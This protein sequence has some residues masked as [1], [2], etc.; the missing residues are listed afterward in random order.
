MQTP[1][2]VIHNTITF[3][4]PDR[5][6]YTFPDPYGSDMFGQ[7]FYPSPDGRPGRGGGTDEW[8]A[9]WEN[10]GVSTLGEVKQYPLLSWNDFPNLKIPDIRAPGRFDPIRG[11]RER[12]GDQFLYGGGMSIYERVHFIRGFENTWADIYNEPENLC[13]LLDILVDMNL[14]VIEQFAAE[15]YDGIIFGDDWGLQDRLMI[16]PAKWREIWKPRYAKMFAAAHAGGMRTM[17]HS[18]GHIVEIMDDLIEAG[19]DVVHMD[20]QENM[21]LD[22]LSKRFA[23]RITF[24]SCADIQTILP[25]NN[26]GLI[27]AYCREMVRKLGTPRGGFIAR[28]YTDPEGVGHKREAI[29][30]MCEE[31]L[32]IGTFE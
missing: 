20:Q 21:G 26:P 5:L 16:S 10:I 28:W 25:T 11:A 13:K 2:E 24:F 12:A 1:R 19:L 18:C 32:N 14:Y 15:Q 9:V 7:W 23:G 4:N 27:R 31:F 8:G 30:V 6:G 22:L 17:L 29:N 3:N